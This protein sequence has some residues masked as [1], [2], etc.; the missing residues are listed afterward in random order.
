MRVIVLQ[1]A[2]LDN[3]TAEQQAA[4]E[5]LTETKFL[6]IVKEAGIAPSKVKVD[7]SILEGPIQTVRPK[8][9]RRKK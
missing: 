7:V 8:P 2:G 1:A 6:E 4:L 9:S 3:L 5:E